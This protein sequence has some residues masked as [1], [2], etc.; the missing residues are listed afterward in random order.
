MTDYIGLKWQ[1]AVQGVDDSCKI[2]IIYTQIAYLLL[3]IYSR[4]MI[5]SC[6][7]GW[8]IFR[9]ITDVIEPIQ[10]LLYAGQVTVDM[11]HDKTR[12]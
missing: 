3:V 8:S 9:D 11:L 7:C 5:V 6:E 4:I 10:T 1:N 12:H 2:K